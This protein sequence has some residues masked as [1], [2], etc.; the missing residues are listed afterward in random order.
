MSLVKLF[1][2]YYQMSNY[3]KGESVMENTKKMELLK[4]LFEAD[5]GEITPDIVLEDWDKWDS[6]AKLSLIVMIDDECGKTLT[7]GDIKG[8]T[9]IQDILDFMD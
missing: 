7:S 1:I 4:E 5:N 8:F 9:T 2:I 3:G 6:M